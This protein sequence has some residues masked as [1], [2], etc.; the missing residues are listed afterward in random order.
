MMGVGDCSELMCQRGE[1]KIG[2]CFEC[3]CVQFVA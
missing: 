2:L 1:V 3:V